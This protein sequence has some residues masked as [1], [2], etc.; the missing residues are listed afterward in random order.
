MAISNPTKYV[1]VRRLERFKQQ[2]DEIY[3]TAEYASDETCEA[4]VDELI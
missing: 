2:L 1:T 4:I 3:Q